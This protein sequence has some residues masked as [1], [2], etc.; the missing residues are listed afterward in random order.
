MTF[1]ANILVWLEYGSVLIS[2]HILNLP[3]YSKDAVGCCEFSACNYLFV[4][5]SF[6]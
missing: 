2:V 1:F 5:R 4:C 3:V 6:L